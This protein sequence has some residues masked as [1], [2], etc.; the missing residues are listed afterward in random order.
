[1]LNMVDVSQW[2]A[3]TS[4]SVVIADQ[5]WIIP[6]VQSVHILAIAIVMSSIGMLNLRLAGLIGRGQSVRQAAAQFFPWIWWA[7]PVLLLTG[8]VMILG[9]PERELLNSYFR[10]KMLMLVA[11]L[12][13]TLP[14]RRLLE[15]QPFRDLPVARRETVRAMALVSLLLWL[16]IVFCGRWIAYA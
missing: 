9:E 2:L 7:L 16:S 3:S 6:M 8:I 4:I 13:L 5:G 15:D 14:L 11:V 10:Y 1:M 12:L